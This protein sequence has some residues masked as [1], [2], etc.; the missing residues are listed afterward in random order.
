[1]NAGTIPLTGA[2]VNISRFKALLPP[3]DLTFDLAPGEETLVTLNNI[4]LLE[5]INGLSFEVI[6]SGSDINPTDNTREWTVTRITRN[7]RIPFRERFDGI[8]QWTIAPEGN[9]KTWEFSSTNL[10]QSAFY[11]AYTNPS[12]GERA[13]LVSPALDLSRVSA[14]SLFIDLSY[15]ERVGSMERVKLAASQD[16]GNTFPVTLF[17]GDAEDLSGNNSTGSFWE[18]TGESDW[19][20]QFF[21]LSMLAGKKNVLVA[22]IVTNDNGNNLYADNLEFFAG[23]DPEPVSVERIFQIYTEATT[24]EERITF[25]LDQRQPVRLQIYS[26]TGLPVLDNTYDD[27]L[28]QTLVFQLN[29]PSG[30]YLY[31]LQIGGKTY[32]EGH[33]VP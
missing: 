5:G 31:R 8:P 2:R 32:S 23:S 27:I 6:P 26:S 33:F 4:S 13:W 11:S 18:P 24:R 30:I 17:D 3:Q 7:N 9:F 15:A 20:R 19:T 1:V 12:P 14:A 21:D 16:C 25:N 29:R 28:N 10:G 22:M